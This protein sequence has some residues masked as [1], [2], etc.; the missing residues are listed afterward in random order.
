MNNSYLFLADGFEEIEA[1][2]TVDI[3]RRAGMPVFTVSINDTPT[4]TGAHDIGVL[5][6]RLYTDV[7]DFND[8]AWLIVPGGLPGSTNLAAYSP[9]CNL[10]KAHAADGGNVAAICAAPAV[11]LAPLGLLRGKKATGYPGTEEAARKEG[12]KMQAERV[13]VD[14]NIVT[15]N[16]PSS[17]LLFALAIVKEALGEDAAKAVADG[18]LL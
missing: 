18:M 1:L 8:A 9:L 5:A 11:V 10:L 15:G 6:D 17:A 7:R 4:V 13:V 3:L 16:G 14:G 2:A 12:A